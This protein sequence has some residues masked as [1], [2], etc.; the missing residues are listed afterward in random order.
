MR[1]NKWNCENYYQ[2]IQ[3][4]PPVII[5]FLKQVKTKVNGLWMMWHEECVCVCAC[6]LSLFLLQTGSG[7]S[8]PGRAHYGSVEAELKKKMSTH[9][10]GA[11]IAYGAE[12]H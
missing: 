8:V 10:L 3:P 4:T 5:S 2:I 11:P 7:H 12:L 9:V 1:F 6:L